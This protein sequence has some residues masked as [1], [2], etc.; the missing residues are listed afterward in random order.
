M[1]QLKNI[2]WHR[3]KYK[4]NFIVLILP[5]YF[6]YHSL[7]PEFPETL[8]IKKIGSFEITAMPYDLDPPY[9]H[10]GKYS[11]DFFITFNQGNIADIKQAYLNIGYEPLPLNELIKS[12]EGILH[13]SKH[14]Q[15]VH[16][17]A[18][19]VIKK[20]HMAWLTIETW[21]G[22]KLVTHWNLP[23]NLHLN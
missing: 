11:K 8:G 15:E 2:G 21:Q 3:Y 1:A 12:G 18:P 7:F 20:D 4:V 19:S 10:E 13:G 23:K 22:E 17:I 9:L 5:F 14:G 16:A 6:L